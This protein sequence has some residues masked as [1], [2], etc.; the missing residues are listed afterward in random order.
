LKQHLNILFLTS[1]YP[2]SEDDQLG[3]FVQYHAHAVAEFCQVHVLAAVIKE[4]EKDIDIIHKKVH[5]TLTETIVYLKKND[6]LS[7]K[8]I[9][10]LRFN[11]KQRGY[12]NGF[13]F[14]TELYGK[15]DLI[16]LNVFYPAGYF[17]LRTKRKDNIP[18][19]L[20]EHWTVFLKNS[21]VKLNW[22]ERKLMKQ[23]A[24]KASV[25]CPVSV[26]LG[27]AMQR[28]GHAEKY[29]VV[30]N[31]IDTTIFY[32]LENTGVHHPIRLIHVSALNEQQKNISGLLRMFALLIQAKMEVELLLIGE[33]LSETQLA[34]IDKLG[35]KET[36]KNKSA[37]PP[38]Q[39][40]EEL[41]K[42]D[43]F[44]LTS[45]YETF[46]IVLAE[47]LICGVPVITTNVDG[48]AQ[49]LAKNEGEVVAVG[50]M[51]GMAAKIMEMAEQLPKY[52]QSIDTSKYRDSYS[53]NA[54]G[55][56]FF[57]IYKKVL[58]K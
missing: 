57:E 53:Q 49:Q 12:R 38:A 18:F 33:K 48:V 20:T 3:N 51:E 22:F 17:A 7:H 26:G 32:P 37:L 28:Y 6:S 2:S 52:K 8:I 35:I 42:S 15:I 24:Q 10:Y 43:L 23:I 47:A 25:I 1:W 58:N 40:A 54:V 13:D 30:P 41:R 11:T 16:H 21:R 50:D 36:V 19:I 46:S 39:V 45:H 5:S 56:A 4:Q 9:P 29:Q 31:T 44:V 34:L 55:N 14:L 27:A